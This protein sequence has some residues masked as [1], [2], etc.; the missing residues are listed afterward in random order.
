[1]GTWALA[2]APLTAALTAF[3]GSGTF[4]PTGGSA[5]SVDRLIVD[6]GYRVTQIDGD[7]LPVNATQTRITVRV[8]DL[9]R[10]PRR[11]DRFTVSGVT[12]LVD[13]VEDGTSGD[14][15]CVVQRIGG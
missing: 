12:Y 8:S 3:G 1:V 6:D 5:E 7:G 13:S 10:R 11:E 14:A 4:T 9:S 15:V 2:G